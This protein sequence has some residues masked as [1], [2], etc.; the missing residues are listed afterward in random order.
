MP[1]AELLQAQRWWG[2]E[3]VRRFLRRLE[4]GENHQLRHLTERQRR[5]LAGAIA[6]K[7]NGQQP[8]M[9][10]LTAHQVDIAERIDPASVLRLVRYRAECNQCG[11]VGEWRPT[12]EQAQAD[13]DDHE[14]AGVQTFNAEAKPTAKG[15][16][17]ATTR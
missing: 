14:E 15:V 6:A 17:S 13:G 2:P 3:R 1:I 10:P 9:N 11:W 16:P 8:V 12:E 7:R 4:I 5:T